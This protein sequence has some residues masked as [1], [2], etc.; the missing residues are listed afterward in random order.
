MERRGSE[1]RA[2]GADQRIA[3]A[4]QV[5]LSEFWARMEARF[6]SKYARSVAAD[7]RL[8]AL[9]TTADRALEDGVSAKVVW[10]AVCVEFD[11][12]SQLR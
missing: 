5:R 3:Y 10:R 4:G 6:G 12:P 9:G 7:Y 11:V 1:L 8:P 2:V